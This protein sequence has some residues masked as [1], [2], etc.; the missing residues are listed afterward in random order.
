MIGKMDMKRTCA[1]VALLLCGAA[2][3]F[4][5]PKFEFSLDYSCLTEH[6]SSFEFTESGAFATVYSGSLEKKV[7]SPAGFGA[8]ASV[9][10]GSPAKGLDL[11][12]GVAASYN[13]F[14]RCRLNSMDVTTDKGYVLSVMG[15]PAIRYTFGER[16][17]LYLCPG[18]RFNVQSINTKMDS[19]I[20]IDYQEKNIMV[21][22][23]GGLR[24]W[25]FASGRTQIGLDAGVDYAIPVNSFSTITCTDSSGTEYSES[26]KVKNGRFLKFYVGLCVN[27]GNGSTK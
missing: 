24:E 17:S 2:V 7:S 4:A 14:S 10:F 16:T 19:D 9:F 22:L 6:S 13:A 8:S 5:K 12:L 3:A 27:I 11:G 20:Q 23:S 1:A 18:M 25:L 26:Y 15:G 21:N